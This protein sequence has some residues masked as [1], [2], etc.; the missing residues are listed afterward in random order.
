MSVRRAVALALSAAL[1]ITGLTATTAPAATA[2]SDVPYELTIPARP[3]AIPPRQVLYGAGTGLVVPGSPSGVSLRWQSLSDGRVSE[4]EGC[5]SGSVFH[6]DKV[7]CTGSGSTPLATVHDF[8][9][10]VTH[11]RWSPEGH[12]LLSAFGPNRQLSYARGADGYTSLYL[13]GSGPDAPA[14]VEVDLPGQSN[15]AP[16]VVAFDGAAALVQYSDGIGKALGLLDFATGEFVDVPVMP[17]T[18][19]LKASLSADWIVQYSGS[20]TTEAFAV[21]RKDTG[22]QGRTVKLTNGTVGVAASLAVLGDWIVGNYADTYAYGRPTPL[23]ATSIT[24][25]QRDLGVLAAGHTEILTGSDGDVY[26]VGGADATHWGVRRVSLDAAGIPVS[27]QVLATP[28]AAVERSYLHLANGRLAV[29]HTDRESPEISGDRSRQGYDLSPADPR[30]ATPTWTCEDGESLCNLLRPTGDG[31]WVV[32]GQADGP[33]APGGWEPCYGCVVK[34]TVATPGGSS[35]TIT[36]NYPNRLSGAEMVSASGRY[37]HFLANEGYYRRSYVADIETGKVVKTGNGRASLWGDRIWTA[38]WDNDT[39]SAVDVRTGATV[40]TVDLESGCVNPEVRTVG[41]WISA[42][43]GDGDSVTVYNRE[44]KARIP[45]HLPITMIGEELHLGDGFLAFSR[46]DYDAGG[47]LQTIDV[48]SGRPVHRSIG[49][50]SAAHPSADDGWTV[51]RFGG[52]VAYIDEQRAIHLVGLGGAT[53]RL[54]AIDYDT[55]A[56]NLKSAPWKPRWW[57][58]KPAASWT[59]S[60]KHKATGKV[61]R[62]LTGGEARGLV[63]PSWDGKDAVGKLVAN[64]AYTWTLTAKAADAQGADLSVTGTVAVSGGAAVRRDLAGSDG[65]GDLVVMDT[66]GLVSMYRG[67]GTGTLSGRI[68]GTGTK[69]PT[70]SVFIP[71]GDLNGDRCA[72]VYVRVGDQLR[73]YRP[74]CD[75]VVSAS[76]PYTLVSAGWGPYDVLTSSGDVNGDGYADLIARQ[77]SSG[78]VYFYAG[79][80]DHRLKARVRIGVNWKPY[81]KIVGAGDLNGDGRGDLLGVDAS[82]VMWRYYGTATGGVSARVKLGGGWSAFS[83]LVGVGDLSGD[84]RADLLARDTAGRLFAYKSTGTGLY[85]AGVMIG[86]GGWNGFKGLY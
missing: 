20:D 38:S 86:S 12:T 14:D 47:E 19:Y 11:S 21:S 6:G 4:F 63:A 55:P 7:A 57:L 45:V 26:M 31:R 61:V 48:R 23:K 65:F 15:V 49:I 37:V 8:T 33:P 44:T 17:S 13:L 10:G 84:G 82:G 81:K 3:S 76:S 28:P 62:T 27:A 2:A 50:V 60:L 9:T 68:A 34:A 41:K 30:T 35:R 79:T 36:L 32:V 39:V 43:C 40:E 64:G 22:D 58:S 73:A 25:A 59:L 74:G 71:M 85:A 77:A 51:D 80:A 18:S 24:G 56:A 69:F 66:A 52:A 54:T 67:T 46:F 83:S 42:L 5:G 29:E 70:T 1:G 75:K 53:T 72:D 16:Q 78:D